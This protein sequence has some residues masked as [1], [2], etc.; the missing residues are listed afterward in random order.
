[1]VAIDASNTLEVSCYDY[2]DGEIALNISGGIPN[3]TQNGI[4]IYI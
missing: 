2:C 4:I 1:M 3:V